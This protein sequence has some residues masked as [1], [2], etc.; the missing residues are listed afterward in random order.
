MEEP[1]WRVAKRPNIIRVQAHLSRNDATGGSRELP[2]RLQLCRS[3][4]K[5]IE[6]PRV[7]FVTLGYSRSRL[8]AS[9]RER[10]QPWNE[11]RGVLGNTPK[12]LPSEFITS[13]VIA[14]RSG[15][16]DSGGVAQLGADK[17]ATKQG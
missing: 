6:T 8:L 12:Q 16:C 17:S 5:R 14:G 13:E 10:I 7:D 9:F 11:I 3:D 2:S 1:L 4:R 15:D